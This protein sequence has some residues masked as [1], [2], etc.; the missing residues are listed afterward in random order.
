MDNN[1]CYLKKKTENGDGIAISV[2]FTTLPQRKASLR[3]FLFGIDLAILTSLLQ[4]L[5]NQSQSLNF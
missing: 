5:S 2:V 1:I 4:R 3:P